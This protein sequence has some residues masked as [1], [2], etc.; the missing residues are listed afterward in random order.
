MNASGGQIAGA[1]LLPP[2]GVFLK[3]G[4]GRDFWVAVGLTVL[5]FVPG[6]VFALWSVFR[7]EESSARR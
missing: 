3:H 2:L 4:G 5:A 1:V 6:M 7:G